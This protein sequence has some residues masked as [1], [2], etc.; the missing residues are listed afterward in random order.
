MIVQSLSQCTQGEW[1]E[2]E[3]IYF[4]TELKAIKDEFIHYLDHSSVSVLLE[5][6]NNHTVSVTLHPHITWAKP[7]M[8]VPADSPYIKA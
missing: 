6:K 7:A 8:Y 1:G 2:T 5:T 3:L 4:S